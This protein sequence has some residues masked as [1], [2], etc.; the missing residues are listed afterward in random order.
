MT[1]VAP[2]IGPITPGRGP[3]LS[4]ESIRL[5]FGYTFGYAFGHTFV[6]LLF[7]SKIINLL[8]DQNYE[9]I[10]SGPLLLLSIL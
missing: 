5:S 7:I 8:T 4:Q 1:P 9:L 6:Q 10:Y 2:D 3:L